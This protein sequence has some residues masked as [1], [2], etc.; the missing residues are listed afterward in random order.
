[1][2]VAFQRQNEVTFVPF[3]D[4][5]EATAALLTGDIERLYIIP[6]DYLRT[7]IVHEIQEER[8]GL[9][10]PSGDGAS[11][12]ETPLG[13]FL[14]NNLFV[15]EV[16]PERANRVLVPFIL[17]TTEV[18]DTGAVV[19]DPVDAGR[20]VFFLAAGVL[21]IVSVFTTS[22]YL[23]Q[24][25]N[26]EKE[27]RIMEVLLSS[28]KP[29]HLMLGKLG[30]LGAAGLLEILVWG[31]SGVVFVVALD[32]LVDLPSDV[33]IVPT[34]PSFLLA[35]PYFILGYFFFGGIMAA[36]GAVTTS[37]REAGQVTFLVVMPGVA[38]LWFIETL[39]ENPEGALARTLSFVPFTAPMAGLARLSVGGMG[40]LDVAISLALL[41]AGV[42]LVML[43][44]VRLFRAY[45][46]MFGQRPSFGQILRTLRGA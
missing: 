37:Q 34:S 45:L 4:A 15:G 19:T 27:N 25:L 44:T 22:G 7:G 16:G 10:T 30:G 13:L 35:L 21:L 14:L 31:V 6:E 18:D 26:E 1:L 20:V 36:L 32:A 17:V 40:S 42:A 8:A 12:N 3:D 33:S 2:F 11:L 23:L 39:L 43:L 46:L 41:L 38:P 5:S 29:E 24:G 28:V 9:T